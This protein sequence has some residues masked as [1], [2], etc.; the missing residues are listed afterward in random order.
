MRA[1]KKKTKKK[2]ASTPKIK[3]SYDKKNKQWYTGE[4]AFYAN[5]NF[6]IDKSDKYAGT[7]YKLTLGYLRTIG[8]FKKLKTAKLIAHHLR[9]G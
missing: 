4:T 8:R 1:K 5:D 3:W 9:H 6:S 7:P 2:Q